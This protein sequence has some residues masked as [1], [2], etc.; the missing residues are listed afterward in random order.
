MVLDPWYI[1][2]MNRE[3]SDKCDVSNMNVTSRYMWQKWITP[4]LCKKRVC[5]SALQWMSADCPSSDPYITL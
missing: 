3:A 4:S 5:L 2:Y 1:V